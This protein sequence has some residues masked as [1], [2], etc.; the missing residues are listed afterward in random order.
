MFRRAT[1]RIL[2][3]LSTFDRKRVATDYWC[4]LMGF[5][6]P[7]AFSDLQN[8]KDGR[9]RAGWSLTDYNRRTRYTWAVGNMP[10][11]RHGE[12]A[13]LKE[14]SLWSV[15]GLA[16]LQPDNN[17]RFC[18][19][20]SLLYHEVTYH[21][22]AEY[23]FTSLIARSYFP[24]QQ[25]PICNAL[26]KLPIQEPILLCRR[27]L[28]TSCPTDISC[29][30]TPLLS[31]PSFVNLNRYQTSQNGPT[32]VVSIT[33]EGGHLL[34]VSDR[35]VADSITEH[36]RLLWT[37]KSIWGQFSIWAL[38]TRVESLWNRW[39]PRV[40]ANQVTLGCQENSRDYWKA[41]LHVSYDY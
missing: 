34:T 2:S 16:N 23:E 6:S 15:D 17:S 8:G 27:E 40:C 37:I 31:G 29:L 35:T 9:I 19:R 28:V 30:R 26:P 5:M 7:Y 22:S 18:K 41:A 14:R 11:D 39:T 33:A 10:T 32:T 12:I 13:Y 1:N 20:L 25:Y 38:L 21:P 4:K 36:Q 24:S 3:L